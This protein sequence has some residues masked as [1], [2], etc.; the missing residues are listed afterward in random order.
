MV[1]GTQYILMDKRDEKTYTI[2]KLADGKVWMTQNLDLDI[3]SN[4]TYTNLDTD[5]GWNGTSYSTANWTPMRSTYATT[6]VQTHEWCVGGSFDYVYCAQN[7]TPESYD[8]G[9]LYWN[10]VVSGWTDWN[11]YLNS[12]DR[13]FNPPSC[14]VSLNPL[15]TYTTIS[16]S[17]IQQYHLGNYYNWAASIASNDA[18]LYGVYNSVTGKYENLEANQSICPAGWRLP[19]A[20]KNSADQAE[21][22]FVDLW[23]EYGWDS[24]TSSFNNLNNLT[25]SPLYFVQSGD[26]FGNIAYIGYASGFQ[27]S[28]AYNDTLAYG[29]GPYM[30]GNAYPSDTGGRDDAFSIRCLL[31]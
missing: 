31:R 11:E 28:V 14:D 23:T 8:P 30:Y 29:A 20:I 7:S 27:A 9:D 21:G 22:D 15:P 3:D 18:S 12:C 25:G 24:A 5:L 13:S 10:G 2:S 4:T 6:T 19:Y 17:P 26:F 1:T 16:G